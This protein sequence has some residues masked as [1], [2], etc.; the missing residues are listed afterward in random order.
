MP[1]PLYDQMLDSLLLVISIA[2]AHK[3]APYWA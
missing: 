1:G 2:G 3:D